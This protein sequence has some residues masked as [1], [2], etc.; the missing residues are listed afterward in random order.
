MERKQ[1]KDPNPDFYESYYK[2]RIENEII[3]TQVFACR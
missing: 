3:K 1:D 2:I